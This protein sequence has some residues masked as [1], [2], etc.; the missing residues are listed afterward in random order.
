VKL[1][2]HETAAL[3]RRPGFTERAAVALMFFIYSF[4]LPFDWFATLGSGETGGGAVTQVTFLLFFAVAIVN[5]TGNWHIMLAAAKREPLLPALLVIAAL[6]SFWSNSF[7][8][9]AQLSFV[10]IVTYVIGLYLVV[11]FSLREILFLA[12]IALALG[13]LLNFAFIFGVPSS[14]VSISPNG[15]NWTGVFRS[16]NSLGRIEVVTVLVLVFNA[17]LR[18]SFFIWPGFA[19]L[20]GTLVVGSGSATSLGALLGTAGLAAG[21]YGFRGRKTLYGATAAMMATLFCGMSVLAATNLATTTGLLGRDTTFTGR[22][23]LWQNSYRYGIL[24]RPWFGHGW[25]AFWGQS[26]DFEVQIRANF[27]VPH[28]HNAFV[29]AWLQGGPLAAV[30]LVLIYSRGLLWSARNIRAD[31]TL[32]GMFPA[33][34]ISMGL[35]YSLSESGFIGRSSIFLFLV[36][37]LTIAAGNKGVQRPFVG[38]PVSALEPQPAQ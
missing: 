20:A 7:F 16:K 28:A 18:H 25:G 15:T 17:R 32:A 38:S 29:D 10:L 3:L 9:T 12:G 6:S 1:A 31:P 36:I 35:V 2:L 23:P 14:G 21:F 5:V 11:R 22:L 37:G 4:S 19:I 34:I 24:E 13:I 30:I 27:D 26:V 33:L 8:V